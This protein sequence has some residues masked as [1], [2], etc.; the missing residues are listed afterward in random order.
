MVQPCLLISMLAAPER[1]ADQSM[2]EW[3][4]LVAQARHVILQGHLSRLIDRQA[5]RDKV[6][7][8]ALRHLDSIRVVSEKQ[9]HSV[10]W[11]L[12]QLKNAFQLLDDPI[13]LLKGAAYAVS[14]LQ[15]S[16]GRVFSDIDLLVPKQHI[17]RTE[18]ILSLHGW[19]SGHHDGYDDRYYRQWMHEIPPLKHIQ[20]RTVLDVH[21]TI[22]PP[23]ARYHPNPEKLIASARDIGQGVKVLCPEDMVIHSATHLFHEGELEHGLRDLVDLQEL[24][25]QF[26]KDEL[27]FWQRLVPRA[28]ELDLLRPLYYG[29]YYAHKLLKVPIPVEVMAQA[30]RARPHVL[31]QPIMNALFERA[32]AP[33]HPSCDRALTGFARWLLYVRS[34][35]LR[36]PLYLLIPH[37]VRKAWKSRMD[38][39]EQPAL[40]IDGLQLPEPKPQRWRFWA[41]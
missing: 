13:L 27:G 6:P 4:R 10:R 28:I 38:K 37:L 32:F 15:A 12:K 41:K 14:D 36:M 26:A 11:E 23:T 35:Y 25:A 30:Q 17:E 22:L 7:A 9:R 19:V 8:V 18:R 33:D 39:P 29:L 21:H 31:L 20:R 34:H 16:H 2:A 40:N 24:L 1:L 5:I 3:D